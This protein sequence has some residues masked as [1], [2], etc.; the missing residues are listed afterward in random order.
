MA[1]SVLPSLLP[2]IPSLTGGLASLLKSIGGPLS[3]APPGGFGHYPTANMHGLGAMPGLGYYGAAPPQVIYDGL[4]NPL[5]LPFL[6]ALAPMLSSLLPTLAS[7]AAKILPGLLSQAGTALP[8]L[9]QSAPASPATLPPQPAP[10]AANVSPTPAPPATPMPDARPTEMAPAPRTPT[11]LPDEV[12]APMRVQGPNG[13]PM[14]VPV[15]LRRRG[16]RRGRRVRSVQPLVIARPPISN[17][18]F[19]PGFASPSNLH[20]CFGFNG[21]RGG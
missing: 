7:G 21:W 3:G 2:M 6:A 16:R 19:A 13:Q 9:A 10:D 1:A 18:G 14:V 20:G 11:P 15:R 8:S 5:G 4:G 12:I 17:F